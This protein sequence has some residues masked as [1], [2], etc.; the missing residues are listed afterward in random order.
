MRRPWLP[1]ILILAAAAAGCGKTSVGALGGGGA[2]A[3][4]SSFS[5]ATSPGD[6]TDL[7]VPPG[8]DG[9]GPQDGQVFP[10]F[11][12]GCEDC[13]DAEPSPDGEVIS[14]DASDGDAIPGADRF[15]TGDAGARADATPGSDA[16]PGSDG[17]MACM[18]DM[19]CGFFNGH[20]DQSSHTCVQ[21]LTSNDC[22]G[23]GVCDVQG[24]HVCRAPCLNGSCG[25]L[26]VCDPSI[27]ACVQCLSNNDCNGGVCDTATKSCVE[28]TQ[29]A[30]CALNPGATVCD[31]STHQCTGC[32]SDANCPSGES[33]IMPSNFCASPMNRGLCERCSQ[34]SD[35][36]PGALCLALPNTGGFVDRACGQDCSRSACPSGFACEMETRPNGTSQQCRPSYP[37]MTPTCTAVRHLGDACD[38][39]GGLD[40][41]CGLPGVQ[42]ARCVMNTLTPTISAALCTV[43][44]NTS[45][46]CPNGRTCFGASMGMVGNCL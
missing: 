35:C 30:D 12:V 17:G 31:L 8:E 33:C 32:T 13:F 3:G 9:G 38:P 42:D 7:G 20:C 39:Q 15:P 2:D 36:A 19:D 27:N 29:N 46:D 11:D 24:G 14:E 43:W 21:C 18:T 45:Q 16:A 4:P 34:D 23:N 44:C 22:P 5:D 41:G 1:P 25:L 10:P 28:C 40:P 37:M 6:F 26:G